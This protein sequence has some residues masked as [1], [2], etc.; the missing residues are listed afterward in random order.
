MRKQI[1]QALWKQKKINNSNAQNQK[2][3]DG[4]YN[5]FVD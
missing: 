5:Q 1:E 4:H 3:S 2:A